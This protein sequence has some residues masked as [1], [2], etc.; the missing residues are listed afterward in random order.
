MGLK[1]FD[2]YITREEWDK[3]ISENYEKVQDALIKAYW[4]SGTYRMNPDTTLN[5][6]IYEDGEVRILY[7]DTCEDNSFDILKEDYFKEHK[8]FICLHRFRKYYPFVDVNHIHYYN[9]LRDLIVRVIK[10]EN[11]QDGFN[12]KVKEVLGGEYESYEELNGKGLV[13]V[14]E[15]YKEFRD[16]LSDYLSFI[17]AEETVNEGTMEMDNGI[18]LHIER[19]SPGISD[20]KF[21]FNDDGINDEV[22]EEYKK[23][24]GTM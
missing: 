16:V 5:V 13:A 17:I 10:K 19:N 14:V 1:S 23:F 8:A 6:V 20:N 24:T 7:R 4:Y 21:Y 15:E 18:R 12:E 22:E 9:E 3:I 2:G 11:Y